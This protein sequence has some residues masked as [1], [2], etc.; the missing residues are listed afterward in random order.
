[1]L[2]AALGHKSTLL[3]A[4]S[5][6]LLPTALSAIKLTRLQRNSESIGEKI[7]LAQ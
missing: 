6:S 7:W 2:D 3:R 4:W 5:T 1:M